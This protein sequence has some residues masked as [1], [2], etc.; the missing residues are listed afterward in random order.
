ML[1]VFSKLIRPPDLTETCWDRHTRQ[2]G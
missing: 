2:H 1:N